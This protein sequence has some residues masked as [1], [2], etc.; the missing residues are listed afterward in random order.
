[1]ELIEVGYKSYND[2]LNDLSP[3]GNLYKV[4][5]VYI[6]RGQAEDWPLLPLIFREE[7]KS[8]IKMYTA[9][10][11][12]ELEQEAAYR[13][14]E[15]N[16]LKQFYKNANETGLNLPN[17][18]FASHDYVLRFSPKD[19]IDTQEKVWLP[20]ELADIAALA[21]H[22]GVITRLIDWSFDINVALYFAAEKAIKDSLRTKSIDIKKYLVIWLLPNVNLE[23]Y[24]TIFLNEN[25]P[26]KFIVPNYFNNPNICAQKGV[27]TYW[28]TPST[29]LDTKVCCETLDRL[30]C[31]ASE[32]DSDYKKIKMYKIKI[33]R[34]ESLKI[35]KY[36]SINHYNAATLFP[37]YYGAAKKIEEDRMIE[38]AE[39]I[40]KK[41]FEETELIHT[42]AHNTINNIGP[43]TEKMS[44]S[45][46]DKIKG[47]KNQEY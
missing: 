16:L 39:P 31:N 8:I 47:A 44:K 7:N 36:L 42:A 37:G 32:S 18:P 4:Q 28:E 19:F 9:S 38:Q 24:K 6:Y 40:F 43:S 25:F 12:F 29:F 46:I 30:L 22:Y 21:Q 27:L 1:M 33:P 41:Y 13:Y 35:I 3:G 15:F 23:A 5:D 14:A 20:K 11:N 45:D 34:F 10:K 2:L 26:L 17:S